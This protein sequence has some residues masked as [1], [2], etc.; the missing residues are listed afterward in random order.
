MVRFLRIRPGTV[1]REAARLAP[2]LVNQLHYV[3]VSLNPGAIYPFVGADT[4]TTAGPQVR[5]QEHF[6]ILL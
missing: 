5:E 1:N 4:G 2:L 3:N 6:S